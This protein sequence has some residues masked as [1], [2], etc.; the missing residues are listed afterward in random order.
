MPIQPIQ[1]MQRLARIHLEPHEVE[2]LG[3]DLA[4]VFSWISQLETLCVR[5]MPDATPLIMSL[6]EDRVTD[7]DQSTLILS[8]APS[9]KDLFFTVPKVL[10]S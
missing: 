6:R 5:G 3:K 8:N 4:K 2:S 9:A 1:T 7:G 10:Q